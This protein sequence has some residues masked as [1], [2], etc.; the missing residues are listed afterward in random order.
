M[1]LFSDNILLVFL[2]EGAELYNILLLLFSKFY[3][4]HFHFLAQA[5]EYKKLLIDY[6]REVRRATHETMT[7]LVTAVGFVFS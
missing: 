5:F 3:A 6:N 2:I 1:G 4:I 7:T